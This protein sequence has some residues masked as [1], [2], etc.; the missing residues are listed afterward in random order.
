M[1]SSISQFTLA[2]TL[3]PMLSALIHAVFHLLSL[4]TKLIFECFFFKLKFQS[5]KMWPVL[6]I[7][8]YHFIISD[9]FLFQSLANCFFVIQ[10][11]KRA[12]GYASP[13]H[14][15]GRGYSKLSIK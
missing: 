8:V 11:V 3:H 6:C 1:R 13:S 9:F 15:N 2:I 4:S 7:V 12:M 5:C 10:G 14:T